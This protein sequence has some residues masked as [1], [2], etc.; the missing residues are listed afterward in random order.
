[1]CVDFQFQYVY[2][3][4]LRPNA[5]TRVRAEMHSCRETPSWATDVLD[6]DE[7]KRR[8]N[9]SRDPVE[10]R[11]GVTLRQAFVDQNRL[12]FVK[13]Y[14]FDAQRADMEM[15]IACTLNRL[16]SKTPC[17]AYSTG[18]HMMGWN[19][20]STYEWGVKS[21]DMVHPMSFMFLVIH[22]MA[23]ATKEFG[24]FA[25]TDFF[26]PAIRGDYLQSGEVL[27]LELPGTSDTHLQL[28]VTEAQ[29]FLPRLLNMGVDDYRH[30]PGNSLVH[31]REFML[32]KNEKT[33]KARLDP[34]WDLVEVAFLNSEE[35]QKAARAPP[36]DYQ[37]L[38]RLLV[39]SEFFVPFVETVEGRKHAHFHSCN[40]IVPY[41]ERGRDDAL[42]LEFRR[43]FRIVKEL[44]M[45]SWGYVVEVRDFFGHSFAVKFVSNEHELAKNEIY[46]ACHLPYDKTP[47][48]TRMHGWLHFQH[49]PKS[50]RK[51]LY[52]IKGHRFIPQDYDL[53]AGLGWIA[54]ISDLNAIDIHGEPLDSRGNAQCLFMLL[55]GLAWARLTFGHFRHRDIK[56]NNIMLVYRE[57][58]MEP[59][60][61][62]IPGLEEEYWELQGPIYVIPKFIDMGSARVTPEG[63]PEEDGRN[64]LLKDDIDFVWGKDI[65]KLNDLSRL[66]GSVF[67]K[68]RN[69]QGYFDL[70]FGRAWAHAQASD[71]GDYEALVQVM[72]E[73]YFQPLYVRKSLKKKGR[74][75]IGCVMCFSPNVTQQLNVNSSYMYCG[76]NVCRKK[77]EVIKKFLPQMDDASGVVH[78]REK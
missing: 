48:F 72:E 26:E 10:Y 18:W 77:H 8:Y 32:G 17:F 7:F 19:F 4:F 54:M 3:I 41:Q 12:E 9:I 16:R 46:I 55:H 64:G 60:L 31:L 49:A 63:I 70:I 23:W 11:G 67:A 27:N 15:E 42:L 2:G 43:E 56:S 51:P 30:V 22:A 36:S 65:P 58:P 53:E 44:G 59:V 61:L 68:R 47:V 76:G 57:D 73:P 25:F 20:V 66:H 75:H 5:R 45:G 78:L 40:E 14:K 33:G 35:Y 71:R 50:L 13:M 24:R 39:T 29:M 21:F 52:N 37:A 69:A 6:E 28:R 74:H 34:D 62:P 1:V 38:V